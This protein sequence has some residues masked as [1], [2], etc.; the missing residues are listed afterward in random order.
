MA[1]EH[2]FENG[3]PFA[4]T[5]DVVRII[6]NI[7]QRT[8]TDYEFSAKFFDDCQVHDVLGRYGLSEDVQK[9]FLRSANR[10][11][12]AEASLI[13]CWHTCWFSD[14]CISSIVINRYQS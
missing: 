9:E 11:E 4:S 2:I 5:E 14:C 1:T 7:Q 12:A 13:G 10:P 8:S 3:V 6:E